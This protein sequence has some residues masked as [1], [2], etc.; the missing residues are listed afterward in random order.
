[1]HQRKTRSE[2]KVFSWRIIRNFTFEGGDEVN[3]LITS[4]Q[5][6]VMTG[7]DLTF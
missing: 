1:M 3:H 2:N 4:D 5:E 6:N 7:L